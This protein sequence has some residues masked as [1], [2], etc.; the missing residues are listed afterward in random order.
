MTSLAQAPRTTSV[1]SSPVPEVTNAEGPD[2]I[3]IEMESR[4]SFW[5]VRRFFVPFDCI[6]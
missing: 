2:V 1:E 3:R 5:A 6:L 4:R